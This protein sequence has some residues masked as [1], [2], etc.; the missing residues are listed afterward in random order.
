M[1]DEKQAVTKKE[2]YAIVWV[3]V[4][5]INLGVMMAVVESTVAFIVTSILYGFFEVAILYKIFRKESE[6][7]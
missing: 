6:E 1:L 2:L 5:L 7:V 4:M 3:L